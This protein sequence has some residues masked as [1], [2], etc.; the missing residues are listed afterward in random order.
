[1][2]EVLDTNVEGGFLV[3][4]I[5]HLPDLVLPGLEKVAF[6]GTSDHNS[7]SCTSASICL[8]GLLTNRMK[9]HLIAIYVESLQI[10]NRQEVVLNR[11]YSNLHSL[12]N[13]SITL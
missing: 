9:A 11:R 5:D 1:M 13:F 7:R 12:N 10:K 8:E 3:H 6:L 4:E 2:E